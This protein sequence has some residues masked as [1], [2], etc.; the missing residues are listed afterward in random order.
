MIRD[1]QRWS[2]FETAWITLQKSDYVDNVRLVE[3]MYQLAR[4][5]GK[6]TVDDALDG[7]EKNIRLAAVLRHVSKTP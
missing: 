7:I 6:F 1:V 3:G 4:A 5:L 2:E